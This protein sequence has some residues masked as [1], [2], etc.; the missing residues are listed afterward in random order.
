MPIRALRG[1][2]TVEQDS[3]ESIAQATREL[4][5][6]LLAANEL[7]PEEI[8]SVIFTVTPDLTAAFP[9]A[10][11]RSLGW[12]T[13]PLLDM[14]AP[15]V[16]NDLPRCIRVLMHVETERPPQAL[17]HVYLRQARHLRPEWAEE[18]R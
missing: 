14:L 13:V 15:P 9:A 11:A 17:R 16:T 8:V 1:A 2:T 7:G 10:A 12:D 6:K 3:P 18:W 5:L 4:L